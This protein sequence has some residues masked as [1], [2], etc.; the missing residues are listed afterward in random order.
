MWKFLTLALAVAGFVVFAC[1]PSGTAG[2]QCMDQTGAGVVGTIQ[3]ATEGS[4]CGSVSG[5]VAPGG[6]C[7][8]ASDCAGVC[9]SCGTLSPNQ[10]VQVAYCM[11]G[12]AGTGVCAAPD[13]TC[14]TFQVS[15]MKA[16]AGDR[17]CSAN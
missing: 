13:V 2:A 17:S 15:E 3:V 9:C 4:G 1:G 8:Y 6:P 5:T 7:M 12:P 16:D 10:S 11:T 14:C